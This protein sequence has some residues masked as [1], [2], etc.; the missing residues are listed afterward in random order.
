[1]F[2]APGKDQ[3]RLPFFRRQVHVP[4]TF[5]QS[6]RFPNNRHNTKFNIHKQVFHHPAED[7][8]L[9]GVFQPEIGPVGLRKIKQLGAYR[10]HTPEMDGAC[11]AAKNLGDI[12][13]HFHPGHILVGIHFS[14]RRSKDGRGTGGF[15]DFFVCGQL[16]GIGIIVFVGAELGGVYK[17]AD[18]D[19]VIFFGS[20][21]DQGGMA[22]VEGTHGGHQTD[23]FA[24]FFHSADKVLQI[25]YGTEQLHN[26][27]TF[28]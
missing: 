4:G 2:Q 6:V 24:F 9:L 23:G 22:F 27:N 13:R 8:R 1:M 11:A 10:C 3:R 15:R 17:V 19:H 16:P 12:A 21:F 7:F 28:R 25:F 20:G 18:D 26:D 14:R 5:G